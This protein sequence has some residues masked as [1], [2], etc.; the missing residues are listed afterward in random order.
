[1]WVAD[2]LVAKKGWIRF[3]SDKKIIEAVKAA[4]A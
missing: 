3:P 2:K 4:L 1:V